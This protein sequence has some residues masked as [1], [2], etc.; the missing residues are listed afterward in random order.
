MKNIF[1]IG[2]HSNWHC[3]SK[4]VIEY[5]YCIIKKNKLK[6]VDNSQDADCVLVNGEGSLHHNGN[7]KFF[8]ALSLKRKGKKV[9]LINSVWQNMN[10]R[11]MEDIKEL[12]TVCVR[13]L[14][15]YNEIKHIRPDAKI[16]T[17]L[18]YFLPI[19]KPKMQRNETVVGGFFIR[20]FS[21]DSE[22]VNFTEEL[23]HINIKHY[24]SWQDYIEALSV[25]KLLISGFHHEIIAAIKL[26]IPFI[27]YR[28]NTDKVL[29][30]IQRAEVNIPVATTPKELF[31]NMK[32]PVDEKEY[33]KLYNFVAAE[34]PFNFAD[35]N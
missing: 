33:D 3:G 28:G 2:N 14:I 26:R 31:F 6:L 11:G 4:A 8:K 18:S 13:E 27:A 5:L 1:I 22:W 15:S 23:R 32:S 19:K 16:F 9:H 20:D 30:I 24:S 34:R 29:G 35:L 21:R 10:F 12:D 7:D 17:D 25:A